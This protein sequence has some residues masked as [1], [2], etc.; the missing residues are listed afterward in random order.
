MRNLCLFIVLLTFATI[1]AQQANTSS[2]IEREF[3]APSINAYQERSQDR[4]QE[5]YAYLEYLTDPGISAGLKKQIETNIY[6]L[7]Q[8]ETVSVVD[9]TSSQ[10]TKIS[11]EELLKKLKTSS[12]TKLALSS[13]TS[14][15]VFG[16]Y[17]FEDYTLTISSAEETHSLQLRQKIHFIK[18]N[19]A[20]GSEE[21]KVWQLQLGEIE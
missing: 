14:T 1:N 16:E 19:K 18:E 3:S 4:V 8:T 21:K 13:K 2:A 10:K 7:F 20:F 6:H 5:F 17:W 11:L 15:P 9:F 12:K